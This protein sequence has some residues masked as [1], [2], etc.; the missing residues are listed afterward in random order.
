[1]PGPRQAVIRLMQ[2]EAALEEAR[3]TGDGR[4]SVARHVEIM[5]AL[6][7]EALLISEER[8]KLR[9]V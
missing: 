4:Y 9:A 6:M 8:P 5:I 7:G 2:E 1:M 3:T